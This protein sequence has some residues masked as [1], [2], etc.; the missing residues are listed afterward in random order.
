MKRKRAKASKVERVENVVINDN[1]DFDIN[2]KFLSECRNKFN[3]N[4]ANVIARN[5]IVATGSMITTTNSDR[6]NDIDHVF[7]N[8]LKKKNTKATNQ[9]RSGRCWMFSGLNMFRHN[10][11]RVLELE[12]FE[13]SQTYLFFWDKLERANS[14]LRWFIDNPDVRR[15]DESFVHMVNSFAEDGGWWS[16]FANLVSKYGVV[17]KSAMKETFQSDDS[18]DM[19]RI[20]DDRIQA[21]ANYIFSNRHIGTQKL[22]EFKDEAI[23][24]VY[25]ILVKFLGEP[26]KKFKWSYTNT[27]EESNIISKLTPATFMDMVMPEI[28]LDDFIVLANIPNSLKYNELYEV[29]YTN[30]VQEGNNFRFLN[31]PME[32]LVKYTAKSIGKGL[33]VWFAADVNHDFNPYHSTLD[34]KLSNQSLVFGES[35]NTFSKGDRIIFRNLQA[36]H[37]MT[38]IGM[39]VGSN[40]KV[41]S[42]QVEN[43]WGYLDNEILGLDGYLFMSNTWLEKNVLQVVIHKNMLSRTIQKLTSITPIMLDPWECSAPALKIKPVINRKTVRKRA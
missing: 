34:D 7:M 19:N 43:S 12:D 33:P 16:T 10:L 5:A 27:D 4:P 39:N 22:L 38:I 37:A 11:I 25:S 14:Y 20:I 40:G 18:E 26:P 1:N 36:N 42:W 6:L 30:N 31:L 3:E 2:D 21:C 29:K 13:F 15:D 41:E 17:P 28:K 8:S 9:G 23:K 35:Q 24:D 32:E